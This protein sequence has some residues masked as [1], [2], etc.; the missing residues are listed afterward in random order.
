[1]LVAA[2]SSELEAASSCELET[3]SSSE[4]ETPPS[5]DASG[6]ASEPAALLRA[7]R[8]CFLAAAALGARR[9]GG[10]PSPSGSVLVA[11]SSSVLLFAPPLRSR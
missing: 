1:M 6:R 7:L 9:F 10:A 5:S 2:S 8:R 4:L 11:A 3:A